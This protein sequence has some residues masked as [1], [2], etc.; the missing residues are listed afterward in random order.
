MYGVVARSRSDDWK[1]RG[2]EIRKENEMMS[3]V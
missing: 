1:R 2:A 3:D